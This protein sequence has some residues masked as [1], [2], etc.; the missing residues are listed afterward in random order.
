MSKCALTNLKQQVANFLS[1]LKDIKTRK[2]TKLVFQH[3]TLGSTGQV[4]G[5]LVVASCQKEKLNN[6]IVCIQ[7][8]ITRWQRSR[9]IGPV[10][11]TETD[12][13]CPEVYLFAQPER[14]CFWFH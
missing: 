8:T 4:A 3:Q 1:C 14:A 5:R 7:S 13:S 10:M 9:E 6:F 11:R 12:C 2:H